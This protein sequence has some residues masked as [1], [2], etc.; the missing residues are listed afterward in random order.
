M[1]LKTTVVTISAF[2]F[3]QTNA[4]LILS[5]LYHF[6]ILWSNH[7]MESE[8]ILL[9]EQYPAYADQ[10]SILQENLVWCQIITLFTICSL[11]LSEEI[12]FII[13][14]NKIM[15]KENS[16][17]MMFFCMFVSFV[18]K[19]IYSSVQ[20]LSYNHKNPVFWNDEALKNK[21]IILFF[22]LS[23][24]FRVVTFISIAGL[25]IVM[26]ILFVIYLVLCWVADLLKE[27]KFNYKKTEYI[28][29]RTDA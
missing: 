3:I 28:E 18:T 20:L 7:W 8:F 27:I 1:H 12:G 25:L 14:Q 4:L 23:Y 22:N 19:M 17:N 24:G 9:N 11:Y 13:Y 21:S 5:T 29:M 16:E 26:M 2:D 6:L 15:A 10:F